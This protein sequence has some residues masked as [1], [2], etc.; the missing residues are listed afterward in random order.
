M[1]C[2]IKTNPSWIA[3]EKAQPK[4]AHYLWNKY[5]GNVPSSYY[6]TSNNNLFGLQSND[7]VFNSDTLNSIMSFVDNIGVKI[8][9]TKFKRDDVLA[10]VDFF[11]QT[12]L[13]SEELN[14]REKAWEKLPE[15]A[16]HWWYRLLKNSELK[17]E[18]W[19]L[20]KKSEKFKELFNID[21]GN[22]KNIDNLTEETI[23]QLIAE[24][25]KRIE[26]KKANLNDKSFWKKFKL[27]IKKLLGQ[28]K[29]Y[30]NTPFDIAA[31]KILNSDLSD[32]FTLEEFKQ[33]YDDQIGE[34]INIDDK[35]KEVISDIDYSKTLKSLMS[36][37]KKR[38]RKPTQ[39][40]I[41]KIKSLVSRYKNLN[42]LKL[43]E[44]YKSKYNVLDI[45][46]SLL[47]FENFSEKYKKGI[48]VKDNFSLNGVKSFD[49]SV[50]N[51]V[52]NIIVEYA[53]EE[54]VK[55]NIPYDTFIFYLNEFLDKNYLLNF[56]VLRRYEDYKIKDT[57]LDIDTRH[58]KIGLRFNNEY[59][60]DYSHFEKSPLAW[61]NIT[62]FKS[63]PLL[64]EPDSVLIHEI[65]ND[66][67]EKLSNK[68]NDNPLSL[69]EE[70]MNLPFFFK[71]LTDNNIELAYS[72][73]K[74]KI[75]EQKELL[76]SKNLESNI[77]LIK[78]KIIKF[79]S[80]TKCG[81]K[82]DDKMISSFY[83]VILL[84]NAYNNEVENNIIRMTKTYLPISINGI[85]SES[86]S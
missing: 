1:L 39:Q 73:F 58:R 64:P 6:K 36:R 44:E 24:S 83:D 42:T 30:E 86:T 80:I 23:G 84:K 12:I 67:F 49:L 9:F 72:Q 55:N 18:L 33:M 25:I 35:N 2:P 48:P 19:N 5:E 26:S 79:D 52:R 45:R 14:K 40:T 43:K 59:F 31:E 78:D 82:F 65:Q 3:L 21:Y 22:Y 75:K 53:S 37:L 76:K 61:G 13:I 57:F 60:E 11:N 27:F 34:F 62:Y 50:Y 15:E 29:K 47:S 7:L 46:P 51:A 20:A 77:E 54:I 71:G 74:A 56:E 66:F 70:V 4:L 28:Y 41:E 17:D 8:D 63:D 16:A 68:S 10:A 69:V 81:V 85:L 32:L 38:K